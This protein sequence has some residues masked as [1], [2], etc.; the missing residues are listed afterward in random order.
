MTM[1]LLGGIVGMLLTVLILSY[2]IGDNPL[3]RLAL[4]VLVGAS[5]GYAVA[6][7]LVTV[8]V[9]AVAP[10]LQ[11]G[12]AAQYG[13]LVPA[14]LGLLLAVERLAGPRIAGQMDIYFT[15]CA[16][17][18]AVGFLSYVIDGIRRRRVEL[19]QQVRA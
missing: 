12:T 7:A 2:I 5:V 13:V 18:L 19:G 6:V 14:L 16:W 4:H 11:G 9:R 10:A 17:G 8:L 15:I 1:E 3:Y